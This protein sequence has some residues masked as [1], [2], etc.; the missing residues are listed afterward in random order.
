MQPGDGGPQ[1][2]TEIEDSRQSVYF[3]HAGGAAHRAEL[4]P[5]NVISAARCHDDEI[6]D[7]LVEHVL[8]EI[9]DE[10]RGRIERHPGGAELLGGDGGAVRRYTPHLEF[11]LAGEIQRP[12]GCLDSFAAGSFRLHSMPGGAITF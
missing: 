6:G 5:I 3:G 11:P 7:D 8:A 9:V 1:R 10:I 12:R 2:S 4:A